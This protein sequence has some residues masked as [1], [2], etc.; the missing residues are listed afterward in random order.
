MLLCVGR[1]HMH[2]YIRPCDILPLAQ[3]RPMMLCIS[4]VFTASDE[5]AKAWE[6]GWITCTYRVLIFQ[7]SKKKKKKDPAGSVKQFGMALALQAESNKTPRRVLLCCYIKSRKPSRRTF[8]LSYV[9]YVP[10]VPLRSP[11][12]RV[13]PLCNHCPLLRR[14]LS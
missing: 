8:A 7:F 12:F 9:P 10:L 4:L 13:Y 1:L 2:C 5:R 3:A 11:P 6:R 14:Q